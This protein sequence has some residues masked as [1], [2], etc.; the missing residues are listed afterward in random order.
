MYYSN[1]PRHKWTALDVM[2]EEMDPTPPQI[3]PLRQKIE[4]LICELEHWDLLQKKMMLDQIQYKRVIGT[5]LQELKYWR[6]LDI[7]N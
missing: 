2:V 5:K 6:K 3:Y 4:L 7:C 1:T